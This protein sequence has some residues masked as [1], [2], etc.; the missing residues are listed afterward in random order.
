MKS[1][2]TV[3]G[4]SLDHS[5]FLNHEDKLMISNENTNLFSSEGNNNSN[6]FAN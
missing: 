5:S 6:S 1:D 4:F 3:S 2:E